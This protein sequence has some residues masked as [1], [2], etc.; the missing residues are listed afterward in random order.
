MA[1]G[2]MVA[3]MSGVAHP[4]VILAATGIVVLA[5]ANLFVVFS[6]SYKAS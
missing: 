3:W 1:L 5:G 6:D 4:W 2:A